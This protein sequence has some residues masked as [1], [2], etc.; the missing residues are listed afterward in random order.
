ML[1]SFLLALTTLS[2][3][4][5]QSLRQ[6]RLAH[7]Y[8]LLPAFSQRTRSG[9]LYPNVVPI[10][11]LNGLDPRAPHI[12]IQLGRADVHVGPH[13][14]VKTKFWEI[15]PDLPMLN[16]SRPSPHPPPLPFSPPQEAPA[17]RPPIQPHEAQAQR[18]PAPPSPHIPPFAPP[19]NAMPQHVQFAPP[20]LSSASPNDWQT[21][22]DPRPPSQ[23]A[24]SIP[25]SGSG[26]SSWGRPSAAPGPA[27]GTAPSA[28]AR[29]APQNIAP[30]P[31]TG[32]PPPGHGN[33]PQPPPNSRGSGAPRPPVPQQGPAA[34]DAVLVSRVNACA[35]L[36]PPLQELLH[37]AASGR[38]DGEQLRM[39]GVWIQAITNQLREDEARAA[40]GQGP[41]PTAGVPGRSQVR[42]NPGDKQSPSRGAPRPSTPNTRS[43][44]VQGAGSMSPPPISHDMPQTPQVRRDS[45]TGV[46]AT[47]SSGNLP[48]AAGPAPPPNRGAVPGPR[49]RFGP[50]PWPHHY[51]NA[52]RP[53][54][55]VIEYRENQSSRFILP[56]WRT[57][58]ERRGPAPSTRQPDAASTSGITALRDSKDGCSQTS[59]EEPE[60]ILSFFLPALGSEAAGTSGLERAE[61]DNLDSPTAKKAP[62]KGSKNG[63]DR[64]VLEARGSAGTNPESPQLPN[65]R[66]DQ[67]EPA[68]PTPAVKRSHK[69]AGTQKVQ[70]QDADIAVNEPADSPSAAPKPAPDKKHERYPVTWRVRGEVSE[71]MWE[72]FGRVPGCIT[73][74]PDG[75]T[76]R[77]DCRVEKEVADRQAPGAKPATATTEDADAA[78]KA[79]AT[80]FLELV[81][82]V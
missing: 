43:P 55:I 3:V 49:S 18:P 78:H 9:M 61:S 60:L 75:K 51:D 28:P 20:R 31:N 10:S 24:A 27:T 39:L 77:E 16:A 80:S 12:L 23:V 65:A 63:I 11:L 54:L 42:S 64:A 74:M 1:T 59:S 58:V 46:T 79:L 34:I 45:P 32:L 71:S 73:R 5:L 48:S 56:L 6:S 66:F 4:L 19:P 30:R 81:S 36:N 2:L 68:T 41:P 22:H 15:R 52:P 82:R 37:I 47:T 26:S 62:A 13:T 35:A 70:Q 40:A 57:S 44:V 50:L 69:K 38:A 29:P 72:A 7:L 8:S 76:V 14:F 17:Q 21:Q 53:P 33:T 67:E 25:S